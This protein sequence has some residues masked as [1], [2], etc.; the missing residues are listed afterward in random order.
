M[1]P[2]AGLEVLV[3]GVHLQGLLD[4]PQ[5]GGLVALMLGELN[6]KRRADRHSLLLQ[7]L[8]NPAWTIC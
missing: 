5:G 2:G 4:E 1:G 7:P 3:G 6:K 8:L